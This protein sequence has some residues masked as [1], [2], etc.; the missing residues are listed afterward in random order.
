MPQTTLIE[1]IAVVSDANRFLRW[2]ERTVVHEKRLVHR[3]V[4]IAVYDLRGRLLVQRRLVCQQ[5]LQDH[6]RANHALHEP[7]VDFCS[8]ERAQAIRVILLI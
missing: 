2:E 5:T 8:H 7:I 6:V 1:P 4:H 3:S